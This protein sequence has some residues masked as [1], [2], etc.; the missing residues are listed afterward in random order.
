MRCTRKPRSRHGRVKIIPRVGERSAFIVGYR[1]GA[2]HSRAMPHCTVRYNVRLTPRV[3]D[4]RAM[5]AI[6]IFREEREPDEVGEP[7]PLLWRRLESFSGPI[8]YEL[9]ER[10]MR[11]REWDMDVRTRI[12]PLEWDI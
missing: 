1:V 9:K 2:V 5:D 6:A 8:G 7:G 3:V 12:G 11:D 4:A 10:V